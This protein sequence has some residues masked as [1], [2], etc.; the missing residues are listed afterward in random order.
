VVAHRRVEAEVAA[1]EA[2]AECAV[3]GGAVAFEDGVEI[4]AEPSP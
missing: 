1:G 3:D 4:D 2:L